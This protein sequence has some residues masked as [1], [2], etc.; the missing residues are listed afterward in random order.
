[1][2]QTTT[3][4]HQTTI[5]SHTVL[6]SHCCIFSWS[7]NGAEFI[8]G[9]DDD[10]CLVIYQT[11]TLGLY[12]ANPKSIRGRWSLPRDTYNSQAAVY[13]II[14]LNVAQ[15]DVKETHFDMTDQHRK[16]VVPDQS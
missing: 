12:G 10:F 8:L 4:T 2:T 5:L 14:S 7:G 1:M 16:S 6:V 15:V 13:F 3:L 9:S 11:A